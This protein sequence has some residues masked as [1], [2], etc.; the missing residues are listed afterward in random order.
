MRS[1]LEHHTTVGEL[2]EAGI[3]QLLH[4]SYQRL[5]SGEGVIGP[6]DD[7]AVIPAP[8]GNFVI[9]TDAMNEGHHFLRDWPSGITDNGY[10]TGWKLAAQNLSDMN[11]MGAVTSSVSVA[12]AMPTT[13]PAAWVF[14]FGRGIANACHWLGAPQTV[15][16]GGDLTRANTLATAITATANLVADPV[17]RSASENVAG[18]QL[19]H[20]GNVGMSH[21]GFMVASQGDHSQLGRDELQALR[22]FLRPRP[23]LDQGPQVAGIVSAMMDVSDSIYTDAD[24]LAAANNLYAHIDPDWVARRAARLQPIADRYEADA[25]QWVL[26]GGE[27]YGLLAVLNPERDVPAGWQVIGQ[28]THEPQERPKITGWDHF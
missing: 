15:I 12:L 20:T 18:F 21:A 17:L 14:H 2:G 13:T 9:A 4:T 6:G 27:D 26:T 5:T 3:L 7:A 24:R 8:G 22:L 10:S 28:L 16:S 1:S 25:T 19:I 23:P 11:A